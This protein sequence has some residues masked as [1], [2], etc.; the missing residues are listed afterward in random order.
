M[1]SRSAGL[2]NI[3]GNLGV[4]IGE[5]DAPSGAFYRGGTGA[6]QGLDWHVSGVYMGANRCSHIYGNSSTVTPLSA[7]CYFMIRF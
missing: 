4:A 2:P 3:T 5:V 1:C 7:T 6:K